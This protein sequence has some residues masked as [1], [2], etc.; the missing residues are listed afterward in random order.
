[1]R[2][3]KRFVKRAL[4]SIE[5]LSILLCGYKEQIM[6]TW[7]EEKNEANKKKHGFYLSDI[8][9]VFD[10]L[11][12]LDFYDEAHSSLEEDRFITIGRFHD[13]VILSVVTTDRKDGNIQII[14][15]R[16]ATPKEEKTY[17]DNYRKRTCSI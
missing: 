5:L 2:K 4:D 16:E 1:M 3:I 11:Y 15:A 10:D 13:A 17:N 8:V 9:D 14:T 7:S 6:F 12:L